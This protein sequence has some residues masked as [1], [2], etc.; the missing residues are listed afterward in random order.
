M[1]A[2]KEVENYGIYELEPSMPE[3]KNEPNQLSGVVS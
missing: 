2:M 1:R 3:D